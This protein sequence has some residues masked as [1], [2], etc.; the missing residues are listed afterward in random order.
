MKQTGLLGL[1]T[2]FLLGGAFSLSAQCVDM[3]TLDGGNKV[4]GNMNGG[5]LYDSIAPGGKIIHVVGWHDA[6]KAPANH[7]RHA[8]MTAAGSDNLC[9]Q[10]SV[11]PPNEST[12]FR[13]MSD[14]Y[15]ATDTAKGELIMM[16]ITVDAERPIIL[17]NYAAVMESPNHRNVYDFLQPTCGFYVLN[18]TPGDADY[19]KYEGTLFHYATD[20]NSITNWQSFNNPDRN[21]IRTVWK[22]W[23]KVGIDLSKWSGKS[24]VIVLENYD[25]MIS[26]QTSAGEAEICVDHHQ[27][28]LY[29][30]VSCAAKR[31][32]LTKDCTGEEDSIFITAPEGFTYRWYNKK[33]SEKTLSTDRIYK[34]VA[35]SVDATYCCELTNHVGSFTL[36]QEVGATTIIEEEPVTLSFG[37]TYT[38]DKNGKTYRVSGLYED[39]VLYPDT[40]YHSCAKTI[41]RLPLTIA[42]LN[43]P[44]TFHV[45]DSIC[46]DA[47]GFQVAFHYD[48]QYDTSD[49]E[50]T[51]T[52]QPSVYSFKVDFPESWNKQDSTLVQVDEMTTF[53]KKGYKD[54]T[55][56]VVVNLSQMDGTITIPIPLDS[57]I[58]ANGDK[59]YIYPRPDTYKMNLI[60]TNLCNQEDTIPLE[61]TILYPSHVIYQ[62]WN[63]V[64]AIYNE[65]YNGG[66]PVSAVRWYRNGV[67]ET[68]L[69]EHG[70]Y[71]RRTDLVS[72]IV[73]YWAE[74]T[75]S[76]D[77]K[78]FCTCRF[79]PAE[80]SVP[81]K[82]VF[83]GDQQIEV[84]RV[85]SRN[86]QV[87]TETVGQYTIFD[88]SGRKLQTGNYNPVHGSYELKITPS[89][90]RGTY[91]L[92]F[93]TAE[94]QQIAKKLIVEEY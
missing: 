25:C 77:G 81:D 22:D 3:T 16:P 50:K 65:H 28:H 57:V 29:A 76:D 17:I 7:P 10:L 19:G 23:S 27:S 53:R 1:I 60:V 4:C 47:K 93:R 35:D 14:A 20:P 45:I 90:A 85:G 41:Y 91:I 69:G 63:D 59:V 32:Y 87:L 34:D 40:N 30:H 21:N 51:D 78:T 18:N 68:A 86:L 92:L 67:Q 12:S 46:G 24:V 55:Q 26:G 83:A 39:T 54:L 48:E 6:T 75:R 52:I 13:L 79:T 71:I 31:L 5:I 9:S 88:M 8:L 38:W 61:Y 36:E 70:S 64:L 43:C 15:Q 66:Y 82:P 80:Q 89:I 72:D 74:I 58:S 11:L 49:D 33:D 2:A 37:Q 42:E 56:S 62:R 73:P 44:G 94:G 84:R